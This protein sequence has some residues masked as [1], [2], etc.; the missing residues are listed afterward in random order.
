MSKNPHNVM[1]GRVSV[2]GYKCERCGHI[3]VPRKYDT[4]TQ[5]P[6]ICP[7]CKSPYWNKPRK[8]S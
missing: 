3:W 5:D 6:V 8:T 2:E 1:V 7:K 4:D